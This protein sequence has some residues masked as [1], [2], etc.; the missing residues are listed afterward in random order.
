MQSIATGGYGIR[1]YGG[2][3]GQIA[4]RGQD[5]YIANE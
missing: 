3:Y 5:P 1:P 2:T 4:R